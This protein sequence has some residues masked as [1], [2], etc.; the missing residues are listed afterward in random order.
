MLIHFGEKYNTVIPYN[1]DGMTGG[2][3]SE[4]SFRLYFTMLYYTIHNK[5]PDFIDG[6]KQFF[7]YKKNEDEDNTKDFFAHTDLIIDHEGPIDFYVKDQL[8]K[9]YR[10]L[11][12]SHTTPFVNKY[13]SPSKLIVDKKNELLEKYAIDPT[14]TIGVYYR[15]TD[16][17][18]EIKKVNYSDYMDKVNEIYTGT[19]TILIQSDEKQ[20]ID[21]A[22]EIFPNC[23]VFSETNTSTTDKGIHYENTKEENYKD[24]QYFYA[25]ILILSQC[26]HIVTG[27]SNCSMWICLYR[28]NANNLH[29]NFYGKFISS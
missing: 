23:V 21:Y 2:F 9:E 17:K 11:A 24:I 20:F 12:F 7:L 29:Q 4:C 28:G 10:T 18:T 6:S 15:G 8:D 16:K 1:P 27:I 26:K 19:E 14:N 22:K 3:F 25:S 5:V 13:F